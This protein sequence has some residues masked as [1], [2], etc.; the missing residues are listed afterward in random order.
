MCKLISLSVL[1]F[2]IASCVSEGK[3]S[4]KN[5]IS[6][7]AQ[8]GSQSSQGNSSSNDGYVQV[9]RLGRPAINEGLV[10]SNDLL[11]A[12]NSIPPTLD[13]ATS[14]PTVLAVLQQAATALGIFD[15]L[16]GTNHFQA[17]FDSNVV[18]GFLPDVMRIDVSANI[19]VSSYSYNG[20]AVALASPVAVAG[21]VILTGGRKIEDDIADIT[22]SY[23]VTGNPGSPTSPHGFT[24]TDNVEYAGVPGNTSQG[25]RKLF[26][27]SS[28]RGAAVFPF[29]ARP[30]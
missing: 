28:Y 14:N 30:Y 21:A 18:K 20:D 24:I 6:E 5:I 13:L 9:E 1:I 26:G 7:Q 3:K 25:H 19:A 8:S 27:Q 15:S 23:L 16:D 22:L 10:L 29:L 11:N 12:F 2:V 17:G 4:K